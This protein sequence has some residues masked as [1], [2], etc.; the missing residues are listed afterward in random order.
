M[1]IR[2]YVCVYIYIYIYIYMY[3]YK[4]TYIQTA[5]GSRG[6]R[7]RSR[8]AAWRPP[9]RGALASISGA[10]ISEELA[11]QLPQVQS[12]RMYNSPTITPENS[13]TKKTKTFVLR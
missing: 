7:A 11:N 9:P 2:L 5:P 6:G 10:A 12:A 13:H 4:H 8:R 3:V 1:Y